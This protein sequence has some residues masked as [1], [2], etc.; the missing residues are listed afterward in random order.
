MDFPLHQ[1]L[2]QIRRLTGRLPLDDASDGALLERFAGQRDQAA[3]AELVRRHGPMVLNVCRRVLHD[4]HS[5]E[6][7][8]QATFLVLVRRAAALEKRPYLGSWLYGVACRTARKARAALARWA[9]ER[10]A[11]AMPPTAEQAREPAGQELEQHI[12]TEELS[13]LPERYRAPLIL[14][15]LQ[16][17]STEDAARHIGC[18]RGTVLSRLARGRERLRGRL[19]R[20]GVTLGAAALP[21]A[22]ADSAGAAVPAALVDATVTAGLALAAGTI[23]ATASIAVL[24]DAVVKEMFALRLRLAAAAVLALAMLAVGAFAWPAARPDREPRTAAQAVAE[25]EVKFTTLAKDI[26]GG[27]TRPQQKVIT[28]Q[29]DWETAWKDFHVM[30][31]HFKMAGRPDVNP[32]GPPKVDFEKQVVIVL[33]LGEK[34]AGNG[35]EIT[36]VAQTDAGLLVHYQETQRKVGETFPAIVSTPYQVIC[37]DK[38]SGP[39]KFVPG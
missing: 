11:R 8:F 6:D 4:P 29:K 1:V 13:R 10:Q 27:P 19:A 15:Y 20:R 39:V 9:R 26:I 38:P 36:R 30:R 22:L 31:P 16:G 37:V 32:A 5:V 35:L 28:E 25:R 14:C 7:A 23:P 17:K 3:F 34:G 2:Q 24:A 33:A 12:V 18:P 21:I